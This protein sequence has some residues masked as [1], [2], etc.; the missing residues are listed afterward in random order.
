MA[1][2]KENF[3]GLD[4]RGERPADTGMALPLVRISVSDR[5]DTYDLV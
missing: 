3:R 4:R 1:A 2:K 5:I